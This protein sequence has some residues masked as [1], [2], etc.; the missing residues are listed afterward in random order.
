MISYCLPISVIIPTYNR[1]HII[2]D[3]IYYYLGLP[4]QEIIVVDDGSQDETHDFLSK[5][6][7]EKLRIIKN[8]KNFKLPKS[9]NIGIRASSS[10]FILMGEDDVII[11]ENY[12]KCLYTALKSLDADFVA[13]RII[14]VSNI[15]EIKEIKDVKTSPRR[16]F[17]AKGWMWANFSI[18]LQEPLKT[19]WLHACGMYK[20]E[21]ALEYPYY[22]KLYGNCLREETIFYLNLHKLGKIG[23]FI[24]NC[25]CAHLK[26]LNFQKGGCKKNVSSE[27]LSSVINDHI[28][29]R[30]HWGIVKKLFNIKGYKYYYEFRIIITYMKYKFF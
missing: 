20:R 29:L 27:F 22:E 24:S 21:L 1:Y 26:P 8:H 10:E 4:V 23:Y 7:N 2:K 12:V 13:G 6:K 16:E 17:Y 19:P 5:I 28:L 15:E 18:K 3:T 25:C 30:N 14:N 11:N 9:R